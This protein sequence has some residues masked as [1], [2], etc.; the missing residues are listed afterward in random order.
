VEPLLRAAY[1]AAADPA[2]GVAWLIDLIGA[3]NEPLELYLSIADAKWLPKTEAEPIFQRLRQW[4]IRWIGYL[5]DTKQAD[6]AQTELEALPEYMR[7]DNQVIALE[8]RIAAQRGTLAALVERY[9][10]EPDKAPP[11]ELLRNSAALLRKSGDNAGARRLLEFAYTRELDRR[12]FSAANFLGLAELRLETG[13]AAAAVALLRR[14]TLVADEPFEDLEAAADLLEKYGHKTEARVFLSERVKA[15]PWDFRARVKLGDA[16]VAGAPDAPYAL[17]AQA[18]LL[19]P[20]AKTGSAELDL[21]ASGTTPAVAAER[22]FFYY[23][24]VK[25]AEAATDTAVR[26]RLLL[27][28][29]AIE[30]GANDARLALFRAALAGGNYQVALS[31]MEPMLETMRYI[32]NRTER[33]RDTDL[34][35]F[36]QQFLAQVGLEARERGAIAEGLAVASDKVGRPGAAVVFYRIALALEPTQGARAALDRVQAEEDR[37]AQ[38]AMRRPVISRELEQERLVRVRLQGGPR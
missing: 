29:L 30:P 23:A 1:E 5:V 35:Y 18:A 22:P 14:M 24:R 25:A 2:A 28:A 6:R 27:G 21:L 20:A 26:T 31:S 8:I 15:V 13:D 37:R 33:E 10:R 19:R 38:D 11:F 17:R 9:Q 34:S 7:S 32:L 12:N 36:E 16:A 4:R 3:A